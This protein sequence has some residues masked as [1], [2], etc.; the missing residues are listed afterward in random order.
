MV[1]TPGD[2]VAV[3]VE[4]DAKPAVAVL[5]A[6]VAAAITSQTWEKTRAVLSARLRH[7]SQT[8]ELRVD[9]HAMRNPVFCQAPQLYD[10]DIHALCAACAHSCFNAVVLQPHRGCPCEVSRICSALRPLSTAVMLWL[11]VASVAAA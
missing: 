8:E 10:R 2:A 9:D 3:A 6:W 1:T 4:V 5:V 11:S 7:R